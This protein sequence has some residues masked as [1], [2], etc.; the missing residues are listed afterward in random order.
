MAFFPPFAVALACV[1]GL[2]LAAFLLNRSPSLGRSDNRVAVEPDSGF[3]PGA[4]SP[5]E[6]LQ[7]ASPASGKNIVATRALERMPLYFIENR[8]QLDPHVAYYVQGRDTALYFTAEGM[9]LALTDQKHRGNGLRGGLERASFTRDGLPTTEAGSRWVVKLDFVGANPNPKVAARDRMPALV[10]YFKGPPEKWKAGLST[11]RSIVYSDLWPGIDLIYSGTVNRLKHTFLVKPGADPA[12]VKLAYRGVSGVRVSEAGQLEVETP[13]GELRDDNPYAYQEIGGL[14]VR[15]NVAYALDPA[16]DGE[17]RRYGFTLDSYD[18]SKPL[19]LDPAMLIYSGY[20]GG[21]GYDEGRGIAV[22]SSGNAY[23]TGFTSSSESSFPVTVGPDL[24][25]NGDWDAFVAKVNAA[26]TELIYAGYIGGSGLEEAHSIAVDSSGNA[27]V[28]G[29]TNSDETTFPVTGGPDLTYNGGY[30]TFVAKVNAAGTALVYAGYIGGKGFENGV[31]I[32]VDSWGNAYVTGL[33]TSNESTFPV[34]AGPD[35]TYNGG[36][37]AFVAKVNPAG[38][39]LVYA[40]YIGGS[41]FEYGTGIA[42]D[43]YGNAFVTGYTGS[44]ETTFPVTVGP[45]LTYNG[46][47]YDAFVAKVNAAGTALVYAGYIGGSEDDEGSGIAVDTSG[48]AYVTGYASSS[49][50]TFPVT[51]GPSL[52]HNGGYDAFAAKINAGGT[53][54]VYA[55]YVGGGGDD[56]GIGIAVDPSGSAYLTGYTNSNEVTF[57]VTVGPGLTYNGGVYD[58][59]VAKVDAGGTRLVYAGYIGGG[60]YDLG[61][62]IAVDSSGNAYVTGRTES[63]EATFPVT[64]G[65]DLTQNGSAD[66]FVTKVAAIVTAVVTGNSAICPGQAATIQADL[67]GNSPWTLTWSD[68][69]S[70]TVSSSPATRSVSPPSTTTYTITSVS[71]AFQAGTSSGSAT[72]TVS[73]SAAVSGS[74]VICKG[75]SATIQATLVGTGPFS[76]TWSDGFVQGGITTSTAVR[77]VHTNVTTTYTVTSVSDSNCVGISSGSAVITVQKPPTA[78]VSGDATICAG[79]STVIQAA[80]TGTPPW[81]LTWSDGFTQTGSASPA[82]RAVSP[83][84]QTKYSVTAV[85][86]AACAGDFSGSATVRVDSLPSAVITAPASVCPGS[87]GNTASVPN[88][89]SGATYSWTITNGTITQGDGTRT[90][91]FTAGSDGPVGLTVVVTKAGCSSTGATM[92]PVNTDC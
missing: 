30:D 10:S 76:L 3:P 11:Y 51:V 53:A 86:D 24:T 19:L 71:D 61:Y 13:A 75:S 90:I 26:G 88:A 82:T 85:S 8:G 32:A 91:T 60:S 56:Y 38:S 77:T 62:E 92:V 40:G 59:F 6:G 57:P 29:L 52:V 31:G 41:N 49:E 54:L 5:Q 83:T 44:N 33:A 18:R 34:T 45:D 78:T 36:T 69:F 65:P 74:T 42:V 17:P 67:T 81:N 68:G 2:V 16:G 79:S 66:V 12:Q 58:A 27:Y 43:T 50:A 9:T 47:I 22:D 39:A 89:A 4:V 7:S 80:L 25:W 23:V 73:P 20:I 37:D 35:L 1:L 14:R 72:V 55:G 28:T 87:T 21:S 46:G 63:T 70:E 64:V 15:V 84:T 48:N